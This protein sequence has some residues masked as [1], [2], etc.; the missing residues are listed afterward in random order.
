MTATSCCGPVG[1]KRAAKLIVD[2]ARRG[3]ILDTHGA[4]LDDKPL[5]IVLLGVDPQFA[6]G[7]DKAK[8]PQLAALIGVPLSTIET[9]IMTKVRVGS[10]AVS[11]HAPAQAATMGIT[12]GVPGPGPSHAP[13][14]A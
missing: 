14:A 3:D 7:E 5:S 11:A 10:A 8:W 13:A 4:L 6:R 1:E 12:F 2:S 9:S